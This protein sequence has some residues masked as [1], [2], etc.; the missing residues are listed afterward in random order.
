[1]HKLVGLLVVSLLIAD[2]MRR[3]QFSV[4]VVTTTSDCD[5]VIC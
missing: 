1:M 2:A 4:A 5:D 3:P